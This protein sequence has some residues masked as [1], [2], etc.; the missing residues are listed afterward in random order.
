[1]DAGRSSR[2]PAGFTDKS[3]KNSNMQT[4]APNT[5]LEVN[6]PWDPSA[7]PI[8]WGCVV[9]GS[10]LSAEEGVPTPGCCVGWSANTG[11]GG[12]ERA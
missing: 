11:G 3:G 1:M 12:S 2:T 6:L 10:A 8:R 5:F 7:L 9:S 4:L